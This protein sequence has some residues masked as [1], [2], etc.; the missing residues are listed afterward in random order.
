MI[1][2]GGRKRQPLT[3]DMNELVRLGD[4]PASGVD[5]TCPFDWTNG[6]FQASQAQVSATG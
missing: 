3:S 4:C 6:L 2:V 1:M 5:I